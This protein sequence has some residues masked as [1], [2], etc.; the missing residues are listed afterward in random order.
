M[1]VNS[2]DIAM[3]EKLRKKIICGKN[4]LIDC[5]P[6][7]RRNQNSWIEIYHSKG[8]NFASVADIYNSSKFFDKETLEKIRNYFCGNYLI[9]ST[10]LIYK[11][12]RAK[13]IHN[14]YNE[15]IPKF[16]TNFIDIPKYK[17]DKVCLKEI[18]ST[19]I[20][21]N[22][23]RLLFNTN[24]SPENIVST[25]VSL[26][27]KN[28]DKLF[29]YFPYIKSKDEYKKTAVWMGYDYEDLIVDCNVD[30]DENYGGISLGLL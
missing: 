1:I 6:H 17:K 2:E 20:G 10:V 7:E 3:S 5:F 27:G 9:C 19:K 14:Y 12:K 29:F 11:N 8:I 16:G 18:L 23:V 25:L 13:I 30:P 28:K 26:S 22:F 15:M 4:E 21:I 24:D